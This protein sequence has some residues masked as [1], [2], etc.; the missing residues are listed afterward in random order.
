MTNLIIALLLQNT[1]LINYDIY[2]C[3]KPYYG[4]T[5][6]VII[7]NKKRILTSDEQNPIA[8]LMF[9]NNLWDQAFILSIAG[10]ILITQLPI[11]DYIKI[12]MLD[13]INISECY[14]L[15]GMGNN[16]KYNIRNLKFKSLIY[17][18]QF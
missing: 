12:I 16:D 2:Q 18:Y 3:T 5:N 1:Y 4:I 17:F 7:N 14:V 6:I 9:K 11:D 8:E 13:L 10:N 15:L